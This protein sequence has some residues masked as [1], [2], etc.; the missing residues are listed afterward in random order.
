MRVQSLSVATLTIS[1]IAL[2]GATACGAPERS[3]QAYP[4]PAP[5]SAAAPPTAYPSP[6]AQ[7]QGPTVV[8]EYA[9]N[10]F[11]LVVDNQMRVVYVEPGGGADQAGLKAGDV[12]RSMAGVMLR[13]GDPQSLQEARVAA[14][15]LQPSPPEASITVPFTVE[16][17]GSSLDLTVA[18]APPGAR[19]TSDQ[20]LPTATPVLPPYDYF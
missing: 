14:A 6:I 2:L 1:L 19:N 3:G 16:R 9:A 18:P 15:A 8:V 4:Y 7:Q 5:L 13:P 20:P 17:N 12:L 11:G 10:V